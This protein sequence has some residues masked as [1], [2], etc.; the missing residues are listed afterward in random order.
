[1]DNFGDINA[2]PVLV[3]A[4]DPPPADHVLDNTDC[5]DTNGNIFPGNTEVCDGKD[6]NC[7]LDVDE[8][9]PDTDMDLVL[10]CMDNCPD[11]SNPGQEDADGDG[12]GDECDCLP[13]DPNDGDLINNDDPIVSGIYEANNS[14]T[15]AGHV[16]NSA[17]VSFKAGMVID[18]KT[19]F[20]AEVGS[21]FIAKIEACSTPSALVSNV[22][23]QIDVP[24]I[25]DQS[26]EDFTINKDVVVK[27]YPNPFSDRTNIVVEIEN[28]QY[29]DLSILNSIGTVVTKVLDQK[30]LDRGKYQ[31]EVNG[32][33]W[34]NGLYYA[35]LKT[36]NET[37]VTKMIFLK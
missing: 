11:I 31:F 9:F 18:L 30:F 8:G 23:N 32:N 22:E 1:M 7:D 10:D 19:G 33:N 27:I 13:N 24:R 5:D 4:G 15:S 35:L 20:T 14:I 21:D 6:N 2:A 29:V 34:K 3:M 37:K 28:G 36:D 26:T 17:E 16:Y 12:F 25:A